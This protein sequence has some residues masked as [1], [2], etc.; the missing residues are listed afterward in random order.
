MVDSYKK[1]ER[2]SFN[3]YYRDWLTDSGLKFCSRGARSLWF[4]MLCYMWQATPRGH[5]VVNGIDIIKPLMIAKLMGDKEEDIV[6]WMEELEIFNVF[7]RTEQNVIISRRMIRDEEKRIPKSSAGKE[8][9][10][11]RWHNDNKPI[12]ETEMCYNKPITETEMCY[13]T[14]E[15]VSITAP[16]IAIANAIANANEKEGAKEGEKESVRERGGIEKLESHFKNISC[17]KYIEL[18]NE[19]LSVMDWKMLFTQA[20]MTYPKTIQFENAIQQFILW[21]YGNNPPQGNLVGGI[22]KCI[23]D[24][25]SSQS[26]PLMDAGKF[27]A[28]IGLKITYVNKKAKR[29]AD[30]AG[31]DEYL[32]SMK[33]E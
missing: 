24:A 1:D 3:F 26:L 31:A 8:G 2:P 22:K 10:R 29:E 13:N 19:K 21:A 25:D 33:E 14:F 23:R 28:Q 18:L 4:D 27:L 11:K 20:L 30:V 32:A 17:E 7:S 16:A 6:M 15:N 12:T 9:M 5:F